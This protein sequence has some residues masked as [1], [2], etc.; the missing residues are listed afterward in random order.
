[1]GHGVVPKILAVQSVEHRLLGVRGHNRTEHC[2]NDHRELPHRA[3]PNFRIIRISVL[4]SKP[5]S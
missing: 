3:Y 5:M 4:A 1:M 2:Q